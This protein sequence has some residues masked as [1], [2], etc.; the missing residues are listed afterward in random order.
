MIS[1]IISFLYFVFLIAEFL[2][3]S[4]EK[5]KIYSIFATSLIFAV[6]S[7]GLVA[8]LFVALKITYIPI[9]LIQLIIF[10]A[11]VDIKKYKK[12]ISELS[13][14]LLSDLLDIKSNY[15]K[16]FYRIILLILFLLFCV[17]FGPINQSDTV[18]YYVGYPFQFFQRNSHFVDGDLGQGLLGIG[19]FGNLAFIQEKSIWLIRVSQYLPLIPLLI[20]LGKRKTSKLNILIFISSPV[21]IQ[22]LTVGKINFLGDSCLS[23]LYLC[24]KIKPSLKYALLTFFVG[25]ISI[26]IKISSLLIFIPLFFDIAI[27]HKLNLKKIFT[28]KDNFTRNH[29]ILF[30]IALGSLL[31]IMYYR[32]NLTQN[33]FFPIFS[34]LFSRDNQQLKD[35]EMML[36]NFDK[37]GLYQIWL[38]IPKNPSKIASVLGPATGILFLVKFLRNIRE[39][40]VKRKFNFNIGFFQLI[41]LLIFAQGRA[42]YYFSPL[43]LLLCGSD[44]IFREN[45]NSEQFWGRLR[46][47]K[48]FNIFVIIQFLLF[49]V[50]SFYMISLNLY[51]IFNYEEIMNKTAYG[52]Y[53][54]KMIQNIASEP[55]LALNSSPARLFYKSNFVPNHNYWKCFKYSDKEFTKDKDKYCIEKL[56]VNTIIVDNNYFKDNDNFSC[57]KI[58]LKETP[59]N[60]FKSSKY[61]VDFCEINKD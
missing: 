22:W 51:A 16:D 57:Q 20:F 12:I 25:L 10:F 4:D 40:I 8:M 24:W 56:K 52:Y 32:F 9:F 17:C 5:T 6:A 50:S 7:N 49:V 23:L 35:W 37:E 30:F 54:S 38:F 61:S 53:N 39:S 59:R 14:K 2:E 13:N 44:D 26:S 29:I 60:I 33:F 31:S 48:I 43:F 15:G 1:T 58:I 36:R 45:L 27:S 18:N 55:V 47:I 19:D 42:D 11:F 21:F 28:N 34:S 46:Q 41:F 3:F